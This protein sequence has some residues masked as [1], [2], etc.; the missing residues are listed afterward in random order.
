MFVDSAV[1]R[2]VKAFTEES[3]KIITARI[4]GIVGEMRKLIGSKLFSEEVVNERKWHQTGPFRVAKELKTQKIKKEETVDEEDVNELS[5]KKLTSYLGK[6]SKDVATASGERKVKN[7]LVGITKAGSELEKR[8]GKKRSDL[9]RHGNETNEEEDLEVNELSKKT[10][11]SYIKKASAD[12]KEH[13][14]K[15][16]RIDG[17]NSAR[18]SRGE[19]L[20]GVEMSVK[21]AGKARSRVKGI[22]KATDK[23]TK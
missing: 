7:R 11:G 5:D 18:L 9:D 17:G 21:A 10:L 13:D 15:A 3:N 19:P 20:K 6:A 12:A 8:D 1:R 16:G 23:L 22:S 4:D 2:D 14:Y